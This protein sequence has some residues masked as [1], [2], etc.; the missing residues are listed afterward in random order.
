MA[1]L[2]AVKLIS[3]RDYEKRLRRNSSEIAWME[4]EKSIGPRYTSVTL[5]SFEIS[6]ETQQTAIDAIWRYVASIGDKTEQ[7]EG[8]I[9]FGPKGTGKDHLAISCLRKVKELGYTTRAEFGESLF[10]RFRDSIGTDASERD[11]IKVFTTPDVLFLSD[12]VPASGA[13]SDHQKSVLMRIIDRRYRDLKPTWATLNVTGPDDAES[14]LG[15]QIVDRLRDGATVIKC[16]WESYRKSEK[17][18]A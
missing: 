14:R 8:L 2:P 1:T 13:L 10:Q 11:L 16:N 18:G 4:V 15:G 3:E 7:G 6:N 5:E 9:L 12:P 17:A